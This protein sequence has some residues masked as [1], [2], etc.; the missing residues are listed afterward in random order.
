MSLINYLR[1]SGATCTEQVRCRGLVFTAS[2]TFKSVLYLLVVEFPKVYSP[3]FVEQDVRGGAYYL[4]FV[5]YLRYLVVVELVPSA[6]IQTHSSVVACLQLAE[7]ITNC[8]KIVDGLLT[9]VVNH[10]R[11]HVEVLD[12][13]VYQ[14]IRLCVVSAKPLKV[15]N[16]DRRHVVNL[17]LFHGL[18]MSDAPVAVPSVSLREVFRLVKLSKAVLYAHVLSAVFRLVLAFEIG[19]FVFDES[20][21][22][23]V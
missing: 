16:Q 1:E 21:E 5:C 20:I 10:K 7:V 4:F 11:S 12:W 22:T 18:L 2:Y 19:V 13:K 6:V 14:R 15:D 3:S 8:K 9:V 23:A 17:Y